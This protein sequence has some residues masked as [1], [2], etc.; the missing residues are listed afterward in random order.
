MPQGILR[1]IAGHASLKLTGLSIEKFINKAQSGDIIL[2]NIKRNKYREV[3]L[4]VNRCDMEKVGELAGQMGLE[5]EVL[6]ENGLLYYLQRLLKHRAFAMGMLICALLIYLLSSFIWTVEITGNET[7]PS[8]KL[9]EMIE[10]LGVKPGALKSS[11]DHDKFVLELLSKE[12][13]F[14]WAELE[15]KGVKAKIRVVEGK[16]SPKVIDYSTPCNVVAGKDG[17]L[18]KLFVLNGDKK[19]EEG[20]AVKKGQILVSG[21]VSSDVSGTR[22][23]HAQGQAWSHTY[24]TGEADADINDFLYRETGNHAEKYQLVVNGK[25]I[26]LYRGEGGILFKNYRVSMEDM[27]PGRYGMKLPIKLRR[28]RYVELNEIDFDSALIMA[29]QKSEESA[30]AAAGKIVPAAG[31]ILQK[32]ADSKVTSD[33]KMHTKVVLEVLEDIAEE[34]AI[35]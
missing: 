30:Y 10:E 24:Y 19:T 3:T 35:K 17:F 7:V 11:V 23:V 2:L 21:M 8:K 6:K 20:N 5:V 1:Y 13:N 4:E 15:I 25:A 27:S 26:P 12:K 16:K 28:V 22:Y 32:T 14:T 29:R 18:V 9:A 31:K 34:K 33:G